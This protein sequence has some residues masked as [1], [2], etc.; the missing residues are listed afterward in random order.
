M[1]LVGQA[2]TDEA[3][4]LSHRYGGQPAGHIAKDVTSMMINEADLVLTASREHRSEVVSML[5]RATRYTFTLNQFARL[6]DAASYDLS[7]EIDARPGRS[8]SP[9]GEGEALRA[10]VV[11]AASMRG[12]ATAPS[13]ATVDDIEDPY[14]RSASVYEAAASA[15]D[16]AVWQIVRGMARATTR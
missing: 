2:M 6:A 12:V 1:A 13:G 4:A 8:D 3:A 16:S 14:R 10:F 11:E 7:T 15:I 9:I 5:P